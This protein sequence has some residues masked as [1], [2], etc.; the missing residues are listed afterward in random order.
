MRIRRRLARIGLP[1]VALGSLATIVGAGAA[2]AVTPHVRYGKPGAVQLVATDGSRA[3]GQNPVLTF[4][5]HKIRRSTMAV[6]RKDRQKICTQFHINVPATPPATGWVRQSSSPLF[7]GWI[8]PGAYAQE[9]AWQWPGAVNVP[10][11][12][13]FTVTW[14]TKKRKKLASATYDFDKVTDYHCTT[15]FCSVD[16][17]PDNIPF[18]RFFG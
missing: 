8:A 7:C 10:Y 15:R 17:T 12:V 16:Q 6:A 11:H 4:P 13:D 1:L 18:V 3:T 14:S 2:Q 5:A 9:S